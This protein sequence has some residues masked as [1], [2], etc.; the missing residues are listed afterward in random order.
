M[1][2]YNTDQQEMEGSAVNSSVH[3]DAKAVWAVHCNGIRGNGTKRGRG[4]RRGTR[5][6]MITCQVG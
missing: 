3:V 5:D 2:F 6:A 4:K 1:P